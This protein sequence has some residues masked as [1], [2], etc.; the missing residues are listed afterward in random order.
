[1]IEKTPVKL[2]QDSIHPLFCLQ[3]IGLGEIENISVSK[4]KW[5]YN[6]WT[7]GRCLT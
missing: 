1:L 6:K 5:K 3:L 7:F 4:W 2:L